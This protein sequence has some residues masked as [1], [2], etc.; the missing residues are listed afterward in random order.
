MQL[1]THISWSAVIAG[2]LA[3]TFAVIANMISFAMI[4]KINTKL[5]ASEQ[6]S[7]LWWGTNVRKKYKELYPKDTLVFWLDFCAVMQ[8]LSFLFV[9]KAWVF[10]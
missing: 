4:G 3:T 5:P 1:I 8:F 6:F 9:V 10:S 2:S 7:Y